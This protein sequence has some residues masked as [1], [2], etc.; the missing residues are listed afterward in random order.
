MKVGGLR[1]GGRWA[2]G[3]GRWALAAHALL[4]RCDPIMGV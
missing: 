2:L 4:W 3:D 1:L